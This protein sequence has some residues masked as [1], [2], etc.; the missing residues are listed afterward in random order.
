MVYLLDHDHLKSVPIEQIKAA[1]EQSRL[2]VFSFDEFAS[3][4][5]VLG[6]PEKIRNECVS[7]SISKFESHEGF[8]FIVL[9]IPDGI[10]HY[11]TSQRV[12]LYLT[13]QMLVFVC[14]D[15]QQISSI[16]AEIEAREIKGVS[17]GKILHLF[18]DRLTV[19]DSL[20]LEKIEQ[21]IAKLEEELVVVKK[22]DF[23]FLVS[24]RKRLL[25]LKVYYEQLLEIYEEIEQNENGLI[26]QKELRYFK[27]LTGRANRLYNG[28]LNLRDYVTQ[29]REAFQTQI[30]INLNSVM[31][32][33]TVITS[34]FFPLTL[35]VGW[36]GMNLQMPEFGWRYGY[37]FVIG[38]IV[39]TAG[40]TLY[41]F[42]K[43][44]WF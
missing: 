28:V 1:G 18:F 22:S 32:V 25:T 36:Y 20:E 7:C 4:S 29:V 31:K 41:Y 13:P 11:S 21:E 5:G 15:Q 12:C 19:D 10:D 26:D 35:I 43:N 3:V 37:L 17:L 8:D 14:N 24:F 16:V 42:K 23:A 40:A 9:N 39:S 34:V 30:D 33:F 6:I 2:C 27:I 38:I 44:K